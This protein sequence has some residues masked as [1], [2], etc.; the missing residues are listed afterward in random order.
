MKPEGLVRYFQIF[1]IFMLLLLVYT[2][3]LTHPGKQSIG[4]LGQCL[5]VLVAIES[6][7]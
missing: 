5:V 4:T 3:S 2:I 7:A 1:C 6:A